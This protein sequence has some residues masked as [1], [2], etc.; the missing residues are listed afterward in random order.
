MKD[1]FSIDE[2]S[3]L[4]TVSADF[5]VA[6]IEE[7]LN[8]KG[9]TLHYFA[10]PDNRMTLAE[11]LA[12]RLPNLYASAYGGLE[13]LCVAITCK[14]KDGGLYANV[15]APRSATGPCLKKLAIGSRGALGM[16]VRAT[17]KIFRRPTAR[18][19]A[20]LKFSSSETLAAFVSD[21]RR[22]RWTCPLLAELPREG[23]LALAFW[24]ERELLRAREN[25]LRALAGKRKAQWVE[26]ESE[27]DRDRVFGLLQEEAGRR[28][29][30]PRP[31]LAPGAYSDHRRVA[32]ILEEAR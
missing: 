14:Q 10:P 21:L 24:G 27:E 2:V 15:L 6:E 12:E 31:G 30:I 16:P 25:F 3:R 5:S 28:L 23:G 1:T 18:I 8:A 9:F 29:K 19:V 7:R 4:L 26:F 17:L 13:E 11:A 32:A 20:L 22:L